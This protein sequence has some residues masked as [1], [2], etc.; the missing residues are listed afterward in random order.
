M[1]VDREVRVDV[2]E[3]IGRGLVET[4]TVGRWIWDEVLHPDEVAHEAVE[5]RRIGLGRNLLERLTVRSV[6][7]GKRKSSIT[8]CG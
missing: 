4:A 7:V 3:P 6:A 2:E 1:R 8:M 5:P